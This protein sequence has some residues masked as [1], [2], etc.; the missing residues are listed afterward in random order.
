MK[1]VIWYTRFILCFIVTLPDR[2]KIKRI[3]KNQGVTGVRLFCHGIGL[4]HLG[5]LVLSTGSRIKITG[6]EH[7]P[8]D[9][10]VLF[11]SNHQSYFDLGIFLG[12]IDKP[13]AYIAKDSLKKAP[14]LSGWMDHMGCVFIQRD[15]IK[16]SA[17]AILEG[18][19]RLE[20]GYSMVVFP[21]GTRSKSGQMG[22]FKAGAFK[23]AT[24]TQV[25]I[26]PVTI[27]GTYKI[28]EANHNKIKPADVLVKIHPPVETKN[29]SREEA[30]KLPDKIRD[31]I[32]GG[33]RD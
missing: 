2:L 9:E 5:P 17:A 24:K 15:N 11:I 14:V 33:L 29:L 31:I 3:Y 25:P 10:T 28:M 22:E 6:G 23:L 8:K 18:I 16:Q 7:I 32:A 13:K 1:S 19:R 20:E 30:L 21:E 26:I 27:N 4:K 12:L